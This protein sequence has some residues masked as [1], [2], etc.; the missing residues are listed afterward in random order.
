MFLLKGRYKGLK[1]FEKDCLPYMFRNTYNSGRILYTP[2]PALCSS[3]SS[4]K[5]SSC[6]SP[7]VTFYLKLNPQFKHSYLVFIFISSGY[8]VITS[9]TRGLNGFSR[10]TFVFVWILGGVGLYSKSYVQY[11]HL[12]FG[13]TIS[14]L[15]RSVCSVIPGWFGLWFRLARD[16]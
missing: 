4:K 5:I 2:Y 1:V 8:I 9:S 12:H 13:Q 7:Y 6:L 3:L 14:F 16:E 11:G 15:P 10:C